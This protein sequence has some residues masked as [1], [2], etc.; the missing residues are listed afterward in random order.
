MIGRVAEG[1]RGAERAAGDEQHGEEARAEHQV[2]DVSAPRADLRAVV[3]A[4]VVVVVDR[5]C[6]CCGGVEEASWLSRKKAGIVL[7]LSST[8]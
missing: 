1:E 6:C 4:K 3:G 5:H 8:V 2:R 7:L